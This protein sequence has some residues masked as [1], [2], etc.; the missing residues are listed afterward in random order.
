MPP[1]TA[2]LTPA[3]KTRRSPV[4]L[5]D[6]LDR[7]DHLKRQRAAG[8]LAERILRLVS[9]TDSETGEMA[10]EIAAT[11]VRMNQEPQTNGTTT[12]LP[13]VP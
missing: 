7:F 4:S 2:A 11:A 13:P 10:L 9:S 5:A 12:D 8:R 6:I 1:K 3:T